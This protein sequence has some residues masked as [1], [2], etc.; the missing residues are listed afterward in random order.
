MGDSMTLQ[1]DGV[2]PVVEG[3]LE[4]DTWTTT[5]VNYWEGPT[6]YSPLASRYLPSGG[7]VYN[8]LA[9]GLGSTRQLMRN[10]DHA[11]T[12]TYAYD[13]FGNTLASSGGTDNPYRYVGALGYRI[14]SGE[15][16]HLGMREYAPGLGRFTQAD[17]LLQQR[18][19]AYARN[20]ATLAVDPDGR[21]VEIDWL[22]VEACK[23]ASPCK[24]W[25]F[26]CDWYITALCKGICHKMT[27]VEC[28]APEWA[29]C[30]D[31]S[32]DWSSCQECCEQGGGALCQA[33][34]RE[35]HQGVKAR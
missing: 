15:S 4:G 18:T 19:Y 17:P 12:D 13:A 33:R 3:T 2:R 28:K 7:G 14:G 9:D 35:K 1:Y 8:Y 11:I 27:E 29:K 20:Q 6:Y 24:W 21:K 16:M 26:V 10:S 32:T 31:R 30:V 22:C 5:A 34:C 23:L 25:D